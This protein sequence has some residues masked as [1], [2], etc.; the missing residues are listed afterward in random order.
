MALSRRE[1][2][3]NRRPLSALEGDA[4]RFRH[5]LGACALAQTAVSCSLEVDPTAAGTI[6]VFIDVSDSQLTVGQESITFTVT[7]RNVGN[8][9]LTF[10]GPSDCLLFVEVRDRQGTLVWS[11]N[12]SCQG[13]IVTE[14]LAVGA[15]KVQAFAWAGTNLA[16]AGL[17]PGLY[18][19]RAVARV[20]GGA[21]VSP[22][23][24]VALD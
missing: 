11:S 1:S 22:M 18:G 8:D 20:T 3:T 10:T 12:G 15:E 6:N 7:A 24:A 17:A 19:V 13:A 5:V 9:P 4:V 21:Y 23:V 14:E 16:G 2:V